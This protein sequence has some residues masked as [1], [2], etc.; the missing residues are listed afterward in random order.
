AVISFMR[1]C[2]RHRFDQPRKLILRVV[3]ID[4]MGD[5]SY[6]MNSRSHGTST[7]SK[8][9]MQ[10]CS[11]STCSGCPHEPCQRDTGSRH[12]IFSPGEPVG[13]EKA[14]TKRG[15]AR[16]MNVAESETYVS[17]LTAA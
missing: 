5:E 6:S 16:R 17:L 12:R 15:S 10:S 2:T 8:N 14:S 3:Y 4:T 13:M 9:S 7:F 11:S 1:M